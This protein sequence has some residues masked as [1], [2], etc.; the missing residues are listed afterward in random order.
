[1]VASC[2]LPPSCRS[3]RTVAQRAM[4]T[5]RVIEV[6]PWLDHHLRLF[7]RIENLS[8]QA[9]IPQLPVELIARKVKSWLAAVGTRPLFDLQYPFSHGLPGSIHLRAVVGSHLLGNAV[10]EHAAAQRFDHM[11][12]VQSPGHADRQTFSCELIEHGQKPQAAAIVRARFHK[13]VAPDMIRFLRSQPNARSL[14]Q[15]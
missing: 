15:P 9:R 13:V 14:V 6:S 11:I 10:L 4:R 2:R 12:T 7:E 1:M 8:V 5:L 3:G